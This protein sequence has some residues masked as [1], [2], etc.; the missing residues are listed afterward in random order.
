[1]ATHLMLRCE[2]KFQ[3]DTPKNRAVLTPHFRA[4]WNWLDPT[5]GT[6]ALAL[7]TDLADQMAFLPGYGGTPLTVKAYNVEGAA[8]NYPLAS[9]TKNPTG[10]IKVPTTPPEV[11]VCLSFYSEQNRPRQRGR[12]YLPAWLLGASSGD[13]AKVVPVG[14]RS[15][16]STLVASFAG[17]GGA[18]V[19][20]IVWSPTAHKAS[21]VTNYFISDAWAIQRR[22][23]I[24]ET[25]RTV[26]TTGG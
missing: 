12:L 18:N 24:K 6:D 10:T 22:R 25:A 16:A 9:Y 8:P 21:K 26:G 7:C 15:A 17:L 4:Q 11:A 14:L 19:D 3:D 13:M 2:F 1:M 20:W 23:G 5:A